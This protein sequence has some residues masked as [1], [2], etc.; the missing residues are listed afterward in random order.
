MKTGN[1]LIGVLAGAAAGAVLSIYFNSEKGAETLKKLTDTAGDYISD[2]KSKAFDG[3]ETVTDKYE[4]VTHSVKDF[5]EKGKEKLH[6][7]SKEYASN[8]NH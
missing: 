8:Y 5:A 1:L 7:A 3:M 4:D 6:D 2:L